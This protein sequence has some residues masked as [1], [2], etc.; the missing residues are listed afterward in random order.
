M[1]AT[2]LGKKVRIIAFILNITIC[3]EIQISRN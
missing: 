1:L 3:E 2:I